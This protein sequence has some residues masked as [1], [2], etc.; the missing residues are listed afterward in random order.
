MK[1]VR[2]QFFFVLVLLQ[3]LLV[4]AKDKDVENPSFTK[5]VE[6]RTAISPDREIQSSSTASSS[7][8]FEVLFVNN[9]PFRVTLYF[10]KDGGKQLNDLILIEPLILPGHQMKLMTFISHEFMFTREGTKDRLGDVMVVTPEVHTY[11][12]PKVSGMV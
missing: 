2:V 5:A 1:R 8:S 11:E 9:S 10:R 12:L 7:E 6:C 4:G 3:R